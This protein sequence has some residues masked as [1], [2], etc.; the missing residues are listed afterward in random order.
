MKNVFIISAKVS[1]VADL[2]LLIRVAT[3]SLNPVDV[4]CR[5]G[6]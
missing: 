4:Q 2:K 1:N 5:N 6:T 3:T